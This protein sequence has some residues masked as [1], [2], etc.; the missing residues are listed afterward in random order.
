MTGVDK[1]EIFDY[2][3]ISTPKMLWEVVVNKLCVV[4]CKANNMDDIICIW[5]LDDDPQC[6]LKSL[7]WKVLSIMEN[8]ATNSL[9][10]VGRCEL[11]DFSTLQLSNITIAFLPPNAIIAS[12]I[13]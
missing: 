2:L 9:N 11:I 1:V 13:V 8:Y 4:V 5:E 6:K 10:Y 7:K 3:Q 12:Y